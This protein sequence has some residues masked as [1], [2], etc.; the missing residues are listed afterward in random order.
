[1]VGLVLT[2]AVIVGSVFAGYYLFHEVNPDPW[3]ASARTA[4]VG[5]RA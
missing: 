5:A 1:V 4:T 2:L 3:E